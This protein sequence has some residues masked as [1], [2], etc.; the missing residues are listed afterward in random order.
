MSILTRV[1][2]LFKADIHGVMDQLEDKE[3][4]IKQY[5]REMENS[6]QNKDIHLQQI[7]TSL[8]EN[9]NRQIKHQLEIEKLEKDLELALR[10]EKDDIARLLI[11]KQRT[12][13]MH[14]KQLKTQHGFL[15]KQIEQLTATI[16]K[17]RLLHES[18]KSK[19]LAF[20]HSQTKNC[21][22]GLLMSDYEN[23]NILA[24][25]EIEL[26]LIRRKEALEREEETV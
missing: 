21:D 7:S 3:L 26:E 1:T 4:L 12:Q 17:Q 5:L 20:C 19:A 16:D 15:E 24:D 22:A 6:L 2:R 23:S 10:K 11:R 9:N 18:L 14:Y 8:T 13:Q 25:D